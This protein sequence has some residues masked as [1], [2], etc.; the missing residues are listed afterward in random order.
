MLYSILPTALS[1]ARF[2]AQNS[3]V[4]G[5]SAAEDQHDPASNGGRVALIKKLTRQNAIA[6]VFTCRGVQYPDCLSNECLFRFIVIFN[7]HQSL[8]YAVDQ[9]ELNYSP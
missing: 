3:H 1:L 5:T 2:V 9:T 6:Y 4:S 7:I 8:R